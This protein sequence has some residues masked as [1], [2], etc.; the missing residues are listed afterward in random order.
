MELD[1]DYSDMVT[2]RKAGMAPGSLVHVGERHLEDVEITVIDYDEDGV[3]QR[4]V[5]DL[6]DVLEFRETE[7]VTWINVD[8]LHD[9]DV[10]E[11]L[12]DAFGIH[13]LLQ[14]DVMNTESRPKLEDF[15]ENLFVVLKMLYT[16]DDLPQGDEVD[17]D[18]LV[19]HLS[20]ILGENFVVTF[21]ERP[22]DVFDGVRDRIANGRGQVRRKGPDY[23]L[24]ALIDAVVDHYF[25]VLEGMGDRLEVLEDEVIAEPDP[26]VL[27]TI[28]DQKREMIF[29]RRS[30]W[31]LREILSKLE[32]R[33]SPLI[34]DDVAI[35]FRD[36]YDHTIQAVDVM[37]SYRD[38]LTG[39]VEVYLSSVSNRTNEVM[40]VLTIMASIFIPLTFVAGVYG[41]NFEH[42]P[43]LGVRWAYPAVLLLMGAIGGVMLMYFRRRGW[44]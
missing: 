20:C 10:V 6:D 34:G 23:L 42:M 17:G 9:R 3:E 22:G 1:S 43:E 39:L 41:M 28:H 8:G 31:P 32:R 29:L 19:E 24:Y 16:P 5:A 30:V 44:L 13:P 14:E 11:R 2:G 26:E 7:T 35:Y 36:V 27:R 33:E 4:E 25:L 18:V 37:Q 40:K 38:V 21:Q 12:C 15:G